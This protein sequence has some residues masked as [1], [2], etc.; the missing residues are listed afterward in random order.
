M[1]NPINT[2]VAIVVFNRIDC[3]VKILES[4]KKVMPPRLYIISDG[5]RESVPNEKEKVLEVRKYLENNITWN[6]TIIKIYADSNLGCTK[7]SVT[8]YDEVFKIEESAILL[9]DDI[10]PVDGFYYFCE[11]M[12]EHYKDNDRI[13]MI[14]G[15]NRI[16]SYENNYDYFYSA[17]PMKQAWAT[18]KNAWNH[19]HKA[20][21]GDFDLKTANNW[22][23]EC[24]N[25]KGV[26]Y[27]YGSKLIR[28][29]MQLYDVWDG[30]WDCAMLANKGIGIV[31]KYHMVNNIGIGRADATY[32]KNDAELAHLPVGDY[33]H[34]ITFRTDNIVCDKSYDLEQSTH[35]LTDKYTYF[36]RSKTAYF[37]YCHFPRLY[38]FLSR[39]FN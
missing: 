8:G 15:E 16:P 5:A 11:K 6:C 20:A 14:T 39:L 7:R 32:M 19:W 25:N 18:W 26:Q 33:E 3:A 13:M 1:K 34:E 29:K 23:K 35:M 30:V 36:L 22:L 4:I 2:A 37:F 27:Y 24:V 10:I 38:K 9:E 12:L 28:C 17:F 21:M 31:S